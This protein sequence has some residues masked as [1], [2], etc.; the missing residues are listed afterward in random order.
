M[1]SELT[2]VNVQKL[3]IHYNC[4]GTIEIPDIKTYQMLMSISQQGKGYQLV[5]QR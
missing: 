5:I 2:G 1:Q 3:T 4:I